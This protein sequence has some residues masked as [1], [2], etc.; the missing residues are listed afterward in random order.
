MA[1]ETNPGYLVQLQNPEGDNVYPVVTADGIVNKD[2]SKFDPSSLMS[3]VGNLH[4]WRRTTVTTSEIPAGYTL[5]DP[6]KNVST[7]NLGR[8]SDD[9]AYF[10]FSDSLSVYDTGYISLDGVRKYFQYYYNRSTS[11]D[12][13]VIAFK[14]ASNE[15][16]GNVDLLPEN[17]PGNFVYF[18]G[19]SSSWYGSGIEINQWYYVPKDATISVPNHD[20]DDTWIYFSKLQKVVGYP[21]IPTE[22]STA[23]VVSQSKK[24]YAE[25]T[26]NIPPGFYL[27]EET[28]ITITGSSGISIGSKIT[29]DESAKITMPVIESISLDNDVLVAKIKSDVVG[30]YFK[31]SGNDTYYYVNN[32]AIITSSRS[33]YG[34]YTVVIPAKQLTPHGVIAKGITTEYM[35]MLGDGSRIQHMTYVGTGTYGSSNPNKLTFNF[36]P[37]IV[38]IIGSVNNNGD[39]FGNLIMIRGHKYASIMAYNGNNRYSNIK[40]DDKTVE[41]YTPINDATFQMNGNNATY[42]VVAIG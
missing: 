30:N 27:G 4:V 23:Y 1:N 42:S 2:G 28:P 33:D 26:D 17:I 20:Y 5:A 6:I 29:V 15:N 13:P 25:G 22:E 39:Y 32:D 24:A 7:V 8:V 10:G 18:W 3:G 38:F 31:I 41:W 35:G 40:W 37:K 11:F 16:H 36:P 12:D 34:I 19:A 21:K 14:N 9:V